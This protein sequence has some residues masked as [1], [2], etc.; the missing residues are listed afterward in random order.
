MQKIINNGETALDIRT[1]MNENFTDL[2]ENKA[3]KN[4]SSTTSDY[5]AASTSNFGHVKVGTNIN[6]TS[7]T[8]SINDA[9]TT[10]KG[11]VQLT[12]SLTDNSEA[13]A[14]TAAAVKKLKDEALVVLNGT[15]EPLDTLGADGNLYIQI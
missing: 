12:S 6:A 8:I 9:S 15:D 10:Q 3:Q 14:A 7:G 4:H 11:V 2:Y 5:G 13:K 1:K